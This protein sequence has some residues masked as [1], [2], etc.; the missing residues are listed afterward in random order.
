MNN[1]PN[2]S[3]SCY[4]DNSNSGGSCYNNSNNN[5]SNNS[6]NSGGKFAEIYFVFRSDLDLKKVKAPESDKN[7]PPHLNMS[8]AI[9]RH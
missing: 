5:N 3:S 8:L 9:T 6:S 2:N 1:N 7:M 4:N